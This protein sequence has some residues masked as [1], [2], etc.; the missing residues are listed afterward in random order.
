METRTFCSRGLLIFEHCDDMVRYCK[1]RTKY[2]FIHSSSGLHAEASQSQGK[3]NGTGNSKIYALQ[4]HN[5]VS[6]PLDRPRPSRSFMRQYLL[7]PFAKLLFHHQHHLAG[8][9]IYRLARLVGQ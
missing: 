3:A 4:I 2:R 6:P 5:P 9:R 7:D 8:I 1:Y